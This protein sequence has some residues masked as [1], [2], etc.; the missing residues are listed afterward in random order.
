LNILKN[1]KKISGLSDNELISLY[2]KKVDKDIAGELYIRYTKFVFLVSMKYLKNEEDS[3]DAVMQIF[4]KLLKNLG[5]HK[6][7]NFKAWLYS[8][9]RNHCINKLK[10]NQ[11]LQKE[12]KKYE[13]E[14][15]SFM[16]SEANSRLRL[17]NENNKEILLE[18]AIK[19]LIPEQEQCINL[20]YLKEKTYSE[21]A[22]ITGYTFNQVKSYIQNGKRNLK[23]KL[24]NFGITGILIILTKLL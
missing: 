9:I 3:K 19:E 15:E 23:I 1:K 18:K 14:L 6:I 7:K 16:E 21:V 2:A 10:Q 20:F 13:K 11:F 8:V 22:E 12:N 4:E 17:K 5:K 24:M